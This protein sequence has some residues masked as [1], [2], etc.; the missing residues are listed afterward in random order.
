MAGLFFS[1]SQIQPFPSPVYDPGSFTGTWLTMKGNK[2]MLTD[3][4]EGMAT[5][6]IKNVYQSNSVIHV[7]DHV[8]LPRS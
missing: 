7:I 1:K 4:K 6:T 2:I 8:V 3:E 5:V